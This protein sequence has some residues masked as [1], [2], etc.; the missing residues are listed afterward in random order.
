MPFRGFTYAWAYTAV[1]LL[2]AG[3]GQASVSPTSP[4]RA[5]AAATTGAVI[6]GTVTGLTTASPLTAQ[7][8]TQATK[9]VTVSVVGTNISTTIDSSS[10]FH[11]TGVPAGDVQLKFAGPGLDATLTLN[12]VEPGDR[13]DIK[14]RLTDTSVRIEAERRDRRGDNDNENEDDEDDEDD[15][16]IEGVVSG[17]TGTCPNITFTVRSVTV[18]ASNSTRFDDSCADVKNAARVEVHGQRQNDGSIQAA[19]IEVED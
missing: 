10:R 17:L 12:D 13:I 18:K 8:T 7:I 9:P 11:L 16:E 14:V 19:R 1:A 3:C 4:S 2:I 15:N 5:S 6:S